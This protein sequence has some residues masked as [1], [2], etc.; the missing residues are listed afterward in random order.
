MNKIAIRVPTTRFIISCQARPTKI[1][2]KRNE[3]RLEVALRDDFPHVGYT[4]NDEE[5]EE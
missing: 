2:E 3:V 5:G 4:F 1:R